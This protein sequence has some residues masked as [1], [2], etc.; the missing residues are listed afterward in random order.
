LNVGD[1]PK[2]MLKVLSNQKCKSKWLW[3]S[4][5]HQSEQLRSKPQVIA[6]MMERM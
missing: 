6:H 4:T 3:D 5:L 2:E 1:A